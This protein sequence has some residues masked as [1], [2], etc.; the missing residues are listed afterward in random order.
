MIEITPLHNCTYIHASR[1]LRSN[2]S[3]NILQAHLTSDLSCNAHKHLSAL[4]PRLRND[5]GFAVVGVVGDTLVQR[6]VPQEIDL[7]VPAD[8]P[9]PLVGPEDR[10]VAAAAGAVEHGHVL[11]EAQD[12]QVDLAEHVDAL[13]GV[14]HG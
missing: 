8:G 3:K 9:H 5:G 1:T 12:R 14:L 10:C 7:L 4:A 13:D 2:A 6:D 11:H